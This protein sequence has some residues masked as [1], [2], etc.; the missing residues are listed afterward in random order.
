MFLALLVGSQAIQTLVLKNDILA[1]SRQTEA[2]LAL[3]REVIGRVQR[4]EDVDVERM[5]GTGQQKEEAE[6]FDVVKEI[7]EEEKIW[8]RKRKRAARKKAELEELEE[9]R[10]SENEDGSVEGVVK[11]VGKE[12]K[13]RGPLFV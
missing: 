12:E 6:W 9:N 1:Y 10:G 8:S 4:G 2:K 13:R 11:V 7:E 5:L 3:L